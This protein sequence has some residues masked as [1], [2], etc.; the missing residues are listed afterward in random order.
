MADVLTKDQRRYCMSQIRGKDTKIEVLL[1]KELRRKGLKGWRSNYKLEGKPDVVY[2][3]EKIAIFCDG[4]FWHG[5]PKCYKPPKTNKKFWKPKIRQNIYRD[6]TV[7]GILRKKGW[8]VIRLWEH[9]LKKHLNK[10]IKRIDKTLAK[11]KK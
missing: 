10:C 6:E 1:R 2:P 3:K 11:A 4:C 8:K 7:N 9:D 5:C